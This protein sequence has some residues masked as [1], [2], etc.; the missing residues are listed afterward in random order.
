V[1]NVIV[2]R[3]VEGSA[4]VEGNVDSRDVVFSVHGK[5][6]ST[7]DKRWRQAMEYWWLKERRMKERH[8]CG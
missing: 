5:V 1:L 7:T 2:E 6:G 3:V 4:T 8:A